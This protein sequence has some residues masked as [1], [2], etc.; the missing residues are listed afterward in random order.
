[1]NITLLVTL[2]T[3]VLAGAI[4][5]GFVLGRRTAPRAGRPGGKVRSTDRDILL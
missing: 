3:L 4:G 5:L 2:S 1:M